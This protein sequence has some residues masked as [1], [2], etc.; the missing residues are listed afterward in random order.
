MCEARGLP[1]V[2]I[3]VVDQ[4]SDA[5]EVQGLFAVSLAELRATS[6]AVL[7]RYFG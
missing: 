1:A 7:P 4:G 3:G 6:E 2:R 5:V